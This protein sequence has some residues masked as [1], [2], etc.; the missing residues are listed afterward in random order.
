MSA[1]QER[2]ERV[3]E[4]DGGVTCTVLTAKELHLNK[5]DEK[6]VNDSPF[7]RSVSLSQCLNVVCTV[8]AD[9][10]TQA[11]LILWMSQC[12]K[13]SQYKIRL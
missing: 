1:L 5:S 2:R 7:F 8:L 11:P 12:V 6:G 4:T 3:M 10:S 13:G 9:T